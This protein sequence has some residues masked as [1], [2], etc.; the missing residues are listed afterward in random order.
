MYLSYYSSV[1]R[2][3]LH[4]TGSRPPEDAGDTGLLVLA[5]VHGATYPCCLL[6]PL[7]HSDPLARALLSHTLGHAHLLLV[8]ALL[9]RGAGLRREA[10]RVYGLA[11]GE[12]Q[13][14]AQS[15]EQQLEEIGKEM[16]N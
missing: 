10:G 11:S 2:C 3:V 8:P 4:L 7:L 6:A 12:T 13:A 16:L 1:S 5:L 15:R 14:E 9:L